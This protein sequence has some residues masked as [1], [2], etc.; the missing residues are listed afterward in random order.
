MSEPEFLALDIEQQAR[1]IAHYRVH[2]QLQAIIQQEQERQAR[3][4]RNQAKQQSRGRRK[5]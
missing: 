4:A 2:H 5:R 3:Q 1:A